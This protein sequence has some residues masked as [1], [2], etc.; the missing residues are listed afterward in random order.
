MRWAWVLV[1]L[2][3]CSKVEPPSPSLLWCAEPGALD[4]LTDPN[5]YPPAARE[6]VLRGKL[7]I[8]RQDERQADGNLMWDVPKDLW[9]SRKEEVGTVIWTRHHRFKTGQYNT[10]AIGIQ[11]S[12]EI[13]ILDQV[14]RERIFNRLFDGAKPEADFKTTAA[15]SEEYS[16]TGVRGST[17]EKAVMA[18]ILGLPRK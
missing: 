17:P 8:I 10:G 2:A 11:E 16:R 9:P 4:D 1:L 12:I 3:S 18:F 6:P 15:Q 13:T 5:N 7:L 14:A